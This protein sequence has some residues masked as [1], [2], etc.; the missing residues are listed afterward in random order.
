MFKATAA[1]LFALPLI[2]CG[3]A[4][5]TDPAPA[6][7]ACGASGYQSLIGANIAAVTL[8]AE[9]NHRVIG[10]NDAYTEDHVPSRL[11][12]FTDENGAIITVR[13]G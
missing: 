2:A 6:A 12:I 7:D 9:L 4:T 10:P 8:P 3:T 5:N 1:A 13:C 11:N